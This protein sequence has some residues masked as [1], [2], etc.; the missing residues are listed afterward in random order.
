MT[1][2]DYKVELQRERI[3]YDEWRNGVKYLHVNNG[4]IETAFND[5][6]VMVE[7][8]RTGKITN[9][10]PEG[11]MGNNWKSSIINSFKKAI[12]KITGE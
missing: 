1:E 12:T 5:G 3:G 6:R 10:Y 9:K 8:C 4:C 7:D 11:Y 2:Y